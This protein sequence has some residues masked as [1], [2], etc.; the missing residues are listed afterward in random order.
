MIIQDYAPQLSGLAPGFGATT[1]LDSSKLNTLGTDDPD[2]I[3]AWTTVPAV[4][5]SDGGFANVSVTEDKT[6][7]GLVVAQ[8]TT[9]SVQPGGQIA[10]NIVQSAS[11][12][13]DLIAPSGSISVATGGGNITVGPNAVI[14]AAGEWIN[15]DSLYVGTAGASTYVN[16]GSISLTTEESG[17]GS[18]LT[19]IVDTT[20]SILLQAGSVLDVSSG[21]VLLPTGALLM[22]N[23]IPVGKGGNLTLETYAGSPY[24][25]IPL[26]QPVRGHIAMDGTIE[27]AGF[28]G[29]GTLT[30]EAL[31]FQIGGDPAQAPSW[32]L[33]LPTDFFAAQGFGGYQLN[34]VY[35]TTVADGATVRLTQQN[36]IP[37]LPA[38]TQAASGADLNQGNL[39][40]LG[41]LDPYHRQPTNLIMTAGAYLGWLPAQGQVRPQY[42]GVTGGVTIGEGASI[43]ADAGANIGLG[44][45]AQVTV[46]G[47]IIAHGG[48]DHVE[49][50]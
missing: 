26:G 33:Y 44:S 42:A 27:S 46:L 20:G 34:A 9:L 1:P 32:D 23:G 10:L 24:G 8:G 12:L 14:S 50:R 6:G 5:L 21:G 15:D 18:S 41:T 7:K 28:S 49:R 36:L 39:T 2:N 11:I 3:L 29:G 30:L 40:T 38:L 43:D 16:G 17:S 37:N 31:G 48:L 25:S 19:T 22:N 35:D 45:P 47:S 4:P 13:G